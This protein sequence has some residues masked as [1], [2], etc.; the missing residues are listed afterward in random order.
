M[1][2]TL[3]VSDLRVEDGRGRTLVAI[4]GLHVPEGTLLGIQGPSGA[5]KSTLLFAL[6]GLAE[7]VSG[8]V[9]WGKTDILGL[10]P[11][12]CSAFR[13][14]QMGFI[15][16]D[17]LLF[18]EL[19]ALA[20]AALPMMYRPRDQRASLRQ[21]ADAVLR[22]L[23]LENELDAP[24]R[25]V[26]RLS[27]GERQRVAIARALAHEPKIL[28]ADEPTANLHRE[29]ADDL[30]ETLVAL[31]RDQGRTLI[32]VSHDARL[33]EHMDQVVALCEGT[34]DQKSSAA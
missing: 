24:V 31:S 33:L 16:Q 5:G 11:D 8:S 9:R 30:I 10:R 21:R 2:P 13:A 6:A 23:G 3:T 28:L 1:S 17:F 4:D 34:L 27:G 26:A 25:T 22:R 18:E 14:E 32:A 12:A 29:A 7:K 15:F 19:G 20:N